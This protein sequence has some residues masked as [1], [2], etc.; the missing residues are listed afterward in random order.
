M[1]FYKHASALTI[2][3]YYVIWAD[4]AIVTIISLSWNLWFW[5]PRSGLTIVY[6]VYLKHIAEYG[7]LT[8]TNW[9][10]LNLEHVTKVS[11]DLLSSFIPWSLCPLVHPH[12]SLVTNTGRSGMVLLEEEFENSISPLVHIL[13]HTPRWSK[14]R[15]QTIIIIEKKTFLID[16][17]QTDLD[18]ARLSRIDKLTDTI[19]YCI[20]SISD[21]STC[22]YSIPTSSSWYVLL[23]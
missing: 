8:M 6:R 22:S 1:Y 18:S 3:V 5:W 14:E 16:H 23:L 17:M 2:Q 12:A 21:C 9:R 19:N 7:H 13:L 4:L 11:S 15:I 10:G 20:W